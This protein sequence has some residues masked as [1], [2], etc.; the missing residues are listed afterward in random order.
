MATKAKWTGGPPEDLGREYLYGIPARDL[1]Q[2]D[3]D[4]LTDEQKSRVLS[5]KSLY[6]VVNAR[7]ES[8]ILSGI[9]PESQEE[10]SE[11]QVVEEPVETRRRASRG[12]E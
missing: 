10:D 4:S 7:R 8:Q 3:W 9:D 1:S 2:E 11:P 5:T 12:G 6:R